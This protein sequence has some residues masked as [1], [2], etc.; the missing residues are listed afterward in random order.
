MIEVN[1]LVENGDIDYIIIESSG[2]SEPIPVAQTFTYSPSAK[3]SQNLFAS[4]TVTIVSRRQFFVK[5]MLR[6]SLLIQTKFLTLI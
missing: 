4:T 3:S 1:R 6:T 2:I 5:S